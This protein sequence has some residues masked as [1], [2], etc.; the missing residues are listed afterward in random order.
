[1]DFLTETPISS[2][3]YA[4]ISFTIGKQPPQP[5]PAFVAFFSS[6]KSVIPSSFTEQQIAPLETFSQEQTM[7]ASGKAATPPPSASPPEVFTNK[8]SGSSGNFISFN[9]I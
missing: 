9:T 6:P 5:V 1:M 7:A 4:I 2:R 3:A 8:P